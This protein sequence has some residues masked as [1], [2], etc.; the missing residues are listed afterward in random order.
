MINPFRFI[1]LFV[2]IQI[3]FSCKQPLEENNTLIPDGLVDANMPNFDS[4]LF[5]IGQFE[6]PMTCTATYIEV[7][8][9]SLDSPAYIITNGHCTNFNYEDNPIYVDV[10][11]NAKVTFKVLAG[12]PES[13]QISF[14]T[15]KIAYAT[16]KGTDLAIVELNHSNQEL[17][18]AGIIPLKIASSIPA[19]GSS[20]QTFGFPL[21]LQPIQLRVSNGTQGNSTSIAEFIWLWQDFYSNNFKNIA[22]GS[23]GSPVMENLNKGIWG[24]V[25][26]TTANGL[27]TCELG[28]PCEFLNNYSPT[29][30]A[31]TT[32]TLDIRSIRNSF[33]N[34]GLF[35]IQLPSN[36]LEKPT[37]FNV[38]LDN[39][40]RNFNR[41]RSINELLHFIS[42]D[43]SKTSYRI[44]LLESYNRKN[45]IGF[46]PMTSD[47]MKV[48]FPE[49]EGF[50]VIS[51]LRNQQKNYLTFKM[52]FTAPNADLIQL[53]QNKGSDGY[54]IEPIFKYPE[55]VNYEWKVG[56]AANC[57][58]ADKTDLEP[59]Y[60]FAKFISTSELPA[61]VC[62]YGFDLAG[63]E[64][65]VKEFILQK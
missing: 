29:V 53:S 52:D 56:P 38:R 22:G 35:D 27:G 39:D 5:A 18:K 11:L 8:N 33:N 64:S 14:S 37:N 40:V 58:C 7:P 34:K 60:R 4:R 48:H 21:S 31:S 6:G 45:T 41:F 46:L 20:I 30:H 49:K 24:M 57:N 1:F 51:F 62:I 42:S 50:Y 55:I 19:L 3:V 47:T 63:N 17:K 44:D 32:Y 9:Q 26:T 36:E 43:Y 28:S 25:N 10:P 13:Q 61:K 59:Y 2:F 65:N 15:K 16:M 12:V 23:S 54:S